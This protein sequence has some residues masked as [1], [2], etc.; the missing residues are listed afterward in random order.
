MNKIIE[1]QTQRLTLRQWRAEDWPAFANLNADPVVMEY[2]PRVLSTQES[3]AMAHRIE[4][5]IAEKGWGFWAVENLDDKQ[6][7]G[8]VGLNNPTYK[9]PITDCVEIGWRLAKEYWGH[10]Y[11]TEAAQA[12]LAVAFEKLNLTEVYSF[13]SVANKKSHAVMQRIGMINTNN[14]FEH[15]IIPENHPLREHVL[16]KIDKQTWFNK[17]DNNG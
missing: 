2:Y 8:F 15:P 3:N 6:F 9:L 17:E 5:L 10:G 11:A 13:A 1:I 12:S 4:S 14:N 7:I 16:Y